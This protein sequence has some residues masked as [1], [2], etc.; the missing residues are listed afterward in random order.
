[1]ASNWTTT[2][3]CLIRRMVIN[4]HR[5]SKI[6]F[7]LK[8]ASRQRCLPVGRTGRQTNWPFSRNGGAKDTSRKLP[9]LYPDTAKTICA[10]TLAADSDD[11]NKPSKQA[12]LA[13]AIMPQP[14]SHGQVMPLC[15][16]PLSLV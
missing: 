5:V 4:T 7:H 8:T 10:G 11:L 14:Y 3:T 15:I 16:G 6:P 1:M 12:S 9:R 13:L 2:N